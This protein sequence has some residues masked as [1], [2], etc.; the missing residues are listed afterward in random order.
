[1]RATGP[2]ATALFIACF[3]ALGGACTAETQVVAPPVSGAGKADLNLDAIT[4][5]REWLDFGERVEDLSFDSDFQFFGFRFG[6]SAG[7]DV[8]I[9]NTQRGS[10]VG[11]DTTL[12]LYGPG[13]DRYSSALVFDNDSGWGALSRIETV[14]LPGDG[15]YLVVVGTA[16]ARGFGSFAIEL[17]CNG[18][19]CGRPAVS[20]TC[21]LVGD[22][23]SDCQFD[24]V[25]DYEWDCGGSDC[26]VPPES[27]LELTFESCT[28]VDAG[29]FYRDNLCSRPGASFDF[30]EAPDADWESLWS[31]C[32][33]TL[34]SITQD[35]F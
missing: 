10:S 26:S 4:I 30:C 33:A 34:T 18:A 23:V 17:S 22:Q 15:T 16:D 27:I 31:T 9:E 25:S 1:M 20:F 28:D 14:V 3:V 5:Q 7:D 11:L 24:Q 8:K 19:S 2:T 13:V 29:Y 21:D 35:D 12:F 6:G 32:P